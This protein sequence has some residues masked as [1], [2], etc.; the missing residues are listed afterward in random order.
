MSL[1]RRI[2][3]TLSRTREVWADEGFAGVFRQAGV[4]LGLLVRGEQFLVDGRSRPSIVT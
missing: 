4:K 3:R 2:S 1:G